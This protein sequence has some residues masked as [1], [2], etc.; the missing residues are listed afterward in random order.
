MQTKGKR[1]L[2]LKQSLF[3]RALLIVALL[4]LVLLTACGG[5]GDNPEGKTPNLSKTVINGLLGVTKTKTNNSF[6]LGAT[7]AITAGPSISTLNEA[8]FSLNQNQGLRTQAAKPVIR[9]LN[10]AVLGNIFTTQAGSSNLF[11]LNNQSVIAVDGAGNVVAS[12]PIAQDGSWSLEIPDE[13]WE[14]VGKIGL[15]QGHESENGFVCEKPLEYKDENGKREDA[16]F[17]YEDNASSSLRSQQIRSAGLFGFDPDTGNPTNQEGSPD[18]MVQ[19]D[20]DFA[21]ECDSENIVK[22][23]VTADFSWNTP[24]TFEESRLY[25]SGVAYAIDYSDVNNP[26][27]VNVAPLDAQGNMDMM[28]SK[29]KGATVPISLVLSD[30]DLLQQESEDFSFSNLD[31]SAMPFTPTFDLNSAIRYSNPDAPAQIDVGD[32]GYAYPTN[33]TTGGMAYITGRVRDSQGNPAANTLILAVIDSDI[34]LAFNF[35]VSQADGSYELLVP[36]TATE[37][38]YY[39]IAQSADETEV[40]IPNNLPFFSNPETDLRISITQANAYPNAD[41]QLRKSTGG[42]PEDGQAGTISGSITVPTGASTEGVIVQACLPDLSECPAFTQ[43]TQ[44]GTTATYTLT[45]LDSGPFTLLAGKLDANKELELFGFFTLDNL[46]PTPVKPPAQNITIDLKADEPTGGEPTGVS[47]SGTVN[48]PSGVDVKGTYVLACFVEN[49]ACNFDKSWYIILENSGQTSP[50]SINN[51]PQ[52]NYAIFADKD[53]TGNGTLLEI[54]DY[55]G[56]HDGDSN[57]LCDVFTSSADNLSV[58]LKQIT[59]TSQTLD[60]R[61]TTDAKTFQENANLLSGTTNFMQSVKHFPSN[62]FERFETTP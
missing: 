14:K 33:Q 18:L 59:G 50:F 6:T 40:G 8:F 60:L 5:N 47:F 10:A 54:G 51:I 35:A 53:G 37:L 41:I 52:G 39:I 45:G 4:S 27:F 36:A 30:T 2:T 62:L 61:P 48:A 22:A 43:I 13:V 24:L 15:M 46:N 9:G 31:A 34:V 19:E 44:T 23:S 25:D 3:Y 20:D 1:A 7:P 49:D 28:I 16:L 55:S 17:G 11:G 21:F 38:P 12:T 32:E 42:N 57:S 29:P 26:S 58:T 56:C